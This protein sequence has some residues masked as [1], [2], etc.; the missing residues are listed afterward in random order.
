MSHPSFGRPAV[1]VAAV[2]L[3]VAAGACTP[4]ASVGNSWTGPGWYL[5]KGYLVA[6]A[7]P[8]YFGGPWSYDKCEEERIKLLPEVATQLLCIRENRKPDRFGRS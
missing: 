7:G 8:A 6:A 4:A 1:Y 3:A 2:C 5:Q